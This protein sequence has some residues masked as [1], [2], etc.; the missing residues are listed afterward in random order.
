MPE[1][2]T[3]ESNQEFSLE[4]MRKELQCNNI[5]SYNKIKKKEVFCLF[6]HYT[7]VIEEEEKS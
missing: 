4:G 2:V 5:Y 7:D 6:K 3:H 1:K